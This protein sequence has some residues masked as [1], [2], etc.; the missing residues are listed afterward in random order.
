MSFLRIL[1]AALVTAFFILLL[2][3]PTVQA[4]TTD[5]VIASNDDRNGFRTDEISR[6]RIHTRTGEATFVINGRSRQRTYS[7]RQPMTTQHLE[8][9][10]YWLNRSG[11]L[12]FP[13]ATNP[14]G[15]DV[16]EFLRQAAKATHG[17][18]LVRNRKRGPAVNVVYITNGVYR[19]IDFPSVNLREKPSGFLTTR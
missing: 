1:T 5:C 11:Q 14:A 10:A 7:G 6:C 8:I 18:V 4:Q 2:A 17:F 3:S 9:A 13:P 15:F 16:Q 19:S 12:R